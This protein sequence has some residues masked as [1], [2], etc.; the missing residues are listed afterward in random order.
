MRFSLTTGNS[1]LVVVNIQEADKRN[2][3]EE[4]YLDFGQLTHKLEMCCHLQQKM[5]SR[6]LVLGPETDEECEHL[7][8]SFSKTK[9]EQCIYISILY[10]VLNIFIVH[11]KQ[12]IWQFPP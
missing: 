8:I 12:R 1:P 5:V 2:P 10:V 4:E 6:E 3:R 9:E 7:N 11:Y